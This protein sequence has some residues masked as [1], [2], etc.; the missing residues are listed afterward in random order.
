MPKFVARISTKTMPEMSTARNVET[1]ADVQRLFRDADALTRK[2][3]KMFPALKTD[4][5]VRLSVKA[6]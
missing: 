1:L 4:K 2:A 6:E 3:C 5:V